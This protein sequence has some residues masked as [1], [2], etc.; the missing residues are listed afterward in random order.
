MRVRDLRWYI[1]GSIV[2]LVSYAA[3]ALCFY[4]SIRDGKVDKSMK[5]LGTEV[6]R[7]EDNLINEYVDVDLSNYKEDV[8]NKLVY[9][10]DAGSQEGQVFEDFITTTTP[11]TKL[12]IYGKLYDL[13]GRD[14][15]NLQFAV[16]A[17]AT[18]IEGRGGSYNNPNYYIYFVKINQAVIDHTDLTDEERANIDNFLITRVLA[19]NYLTKV[20]EVENKLLGSDAFY[21]TFTSDSIVHSSDTTKVNQA[22]SIED[23]SPDYKKDIEKNGYSTAVRSINGKRYIVSV[24]ENDYYGYLCLAM[25]LSHVYFGIDWVYQQA[26]IFYFAGVIIMALMLG[27]FILGCRRTSQLLRADRHSLEKTEAI[28]IRIALNGDIIFSNKTFKKLYGI[29]REVK[30]SD[31]IDVETNEPIL[32]TIKKN[33]AFICEIPLDEIRDRVAY[34]QLSP[35]N[36]SRS[37]YLMGTDVTLEYNESQRLQLMSGRNEIT[38]C[39]NGFILS[40]K[41]QKII[42]EDTAGLDVAFVEIN[43]HK[44]NDLIQIFG[45][46][47]YNLMSVEFV[48]MLKQVFEDMNIYHIDVSK[49]MI[50]YPNTSMDEVGMKV[51]EL[52][53]TLKRPL[54]IKANNIYINAKI[55]AYNLK[56]DAID[57][58]FVEIDEER[59]IKLKDIETK[60]DLAYRNMGELSSKD[61]IVYEPAMD[62]IILATDEMEKDIETGLIDKEFQ[63]YL[64]P[65]FDIVNNRVDGF[66]ALIRWMNPKYKDK[67]PQ[68]FIELAERRGHML[69]IGRF[70]ITESF[71]LAKKLEPYGV[72]ISVNISPVQLLQVG[73]VQQLID[74]YNRNQLKTGSVAIEITETL[75]M[76]SFH[77]VAEKLRL[78]KEAGFHIHLDDFCTG[79]S[80]M[81]YLKDLPVD[82]IKID[83]EFTKYIVT[84]KYNENIVK[85]ICTLANDLKLEIICEGVEQQEQ[86]DMVK[87][88]GCR[89]IQGWLYGKAMPYDQ[90]V[91]MLEKYNTGS[92]KRK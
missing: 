61:Y 42:K 28:V 87:K 37:Y 83:K 31:F 16:Y 8:N 5:E 89:T 40:T 49:F 75:L 56:R 7:Y 17:Q 39:E 4:L 22:D 59:Q 81:L 23:I 78:L 26:L 69:D 24:V 79:Y 46:T 88:F 35:L 25:P 74:E 70:V 38:N 57:Q 67:S 45:R 30:L 58:S 52:L 1:L 9:K 14:E 41:F 90:A 21:F 18:T 73:F 76:G 20:A 44:F 53:E 54:T 91:D 15:S 19:E 10:T 13:N 80:S 34:L 71:K 84:N 47:T 32:N 29:T 72:H 77:L 27:L 55:V 63:M 65:Q 92:S 66:E 12:Q 62:N 86:A 48:K 11:N 82:T 3:I 6:I 64:Q 33:K 2:L 60:L 51:N 43:I 36:I 68:V 85:T 50:V